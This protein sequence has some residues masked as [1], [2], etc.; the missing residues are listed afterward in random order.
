[1]YWDVEGTF[2]ES[3]F[4]EGETVRLL[5]YEDRQVVLV[6]EVFYQTTGFSFQAV[7]GKEYLLRFMT[8]GQNKLVI[9]TLENY[10]SD[11][12]TE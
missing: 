6:N 2:T 8:M 1:M 5:V 3:D 11:T 9:M 12:K 4:R 10:V 7:K